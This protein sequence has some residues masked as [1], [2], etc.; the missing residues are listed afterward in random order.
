MGHKDASLINRILCVTL[1]ALLICTVWWSSSAWGFDG[2]SR[3]IL[4]DEGV[5][6][7]A[8]PDTP[9]ASE[10]A[11]GSLQDNADALPEADSAEVAADAA[12]EAAK[13]LAASE[14]A[15]VPS[16]A[17]GPYENAQSDDLAM[18]STE[19][20]EPGDTSTAPQVSQ[21]EA[22]EAADERATDPA[23]LGYIPG[24]IVVVYEDVLES[25]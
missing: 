5:P 8:T 22:A 9:E 11:G 6:M 12:F 4:G 19:A 7:A 21:E 10:A 24:E 20:P 25:G 1:S 17:G 16:F 14:E 2:R 13:E 15:L 23:E 3:N 18:A